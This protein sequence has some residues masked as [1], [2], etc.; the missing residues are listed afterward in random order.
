MNQKAISVVPYL[1]SFF[2]IIIIMFYFYNFVFCIFRATPT[3][4]G[5]S[6]ARDIIG[7]TATGLHHGPSSK[8][9]EPH[10]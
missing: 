3:A 1:N 10:L 8:G 9:S 4:Y 6:Q 5:G 7:A 2:K